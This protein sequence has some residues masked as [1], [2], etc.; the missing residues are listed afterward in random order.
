MSEQ[1]NL[2][3]LEL[4]PTEKPNVFPDEHSVPEHYEFPPDPEAPDLSVEEDVVTDQ[5]EETP[6]DA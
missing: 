2:D 3:D 5:E 4:D 6:D 1:P